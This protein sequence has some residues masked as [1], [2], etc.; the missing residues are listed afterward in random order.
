MIDVGLVGFG[1]GGKAF[2]A[3]VIAAVDGLR[4]AAVLQRHEKSA[5]EMYPGVKVVR[6]VQELL[7]IESIKLVAISTPNVFGRMWEWQASSAVQA[8]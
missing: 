1:L 4:L 2:H 6:T 7:A 8:T 3:P 5:A